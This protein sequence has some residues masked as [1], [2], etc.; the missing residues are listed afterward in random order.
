MIKQKLFSQHHSILYLR[1]WYKSHYILAL[2]T[3][4]LKAKQRKHVCKKNIESF[5]PPPLLPLI[6]PS[7]IIK[8]YFWLLIWSPE[9]SFYC[10]CGSWKHI[11]QIIRGR[12]SKCFWC[13]ADPKCC[14]VLFPDV[15]SRV[16]TAWMWVGFRLKE[17]ISMQKAFLC[18]FRAWGIEKKKI[19]H[20]YTTVCIGSLHLSWSALDHRN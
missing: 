12:W 1:M 17:K 4:T 11:L 10:G 5:F 7:H 9:I 14:S 19:T 13:L 6:L 18:S 8:Y 20:C 15:F 2:I 3:D 16:F